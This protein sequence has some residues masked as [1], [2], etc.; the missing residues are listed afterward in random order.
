MSTIREALSRAGIDVKPLDDLNFDLD[1]LPSDDFVSQV[2]ENRVY[3]DA[4]YYNTVYAVAVRCLAE[5]RNNYERLSRKLSDSL[6]GALRTLGKPCTLEALR[7]V[8]SLPE[9][10]THLL[11]AFDSK[12]GWLPKLR[13]RLLP[14]TDPGGTPSSRIKSFPAKLTAA[15]FQDLEDLAYLDSNDF[16]KLVGSLKVSKGTAITVYQQAKTI[17]G[18]SNKVL[19][20][21]LDHATVIKSLITTV[22]KAVTNATLVS[23]N[24][25]NLINFIRRDCCSPSGDS[26]AFDKLDGS[27]DFITIGLFG[28]LTLITNFLVRIGAFPE[29]NKLPANNGQAEIHA[30]TTRFAECSAMRG[31]SVMIL[32]FV[33]GSTSFSNVQESDPAC[34]FLRFL[35]TLCDRIFMCLSEVMLTEL[36][37]EIGEAEARRLFECEVEKTSIKEDRCEFRKGFAQDLSLPPSDSPWTMIQGDNRVGFVCWEEINE[38]TV[39]TPLTGQIPISYFTGQFK[40]LLDGRE[41]CT[42]ILPY[43]N[44]LALL[45]LLNPT[46]AQALEE[47]NKRRIRNLQSVAKDQI[48]R[49]LMKYFQHEWELLLLKAPRSLSDCSAD[50]TSRRDA[51]GICLSK[52]TSVVFPSRSLSDCSAELDQTRLRDFVA[53]CLSKITSVVFLFEEFFPDKTQ[54]QLRDFLSLTEHE[55]KQRISQFA[56]DPP[57][58]HVPLSTFSSLAFEPHFVSEITSALKKKFTSQYKSLLKEIQDDVCNN[59]EKFCPTFLID[60]DT[61]IRTETASSQLRK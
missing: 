31:K 26:I 24:V 38:S 41:L 54:R 12:V 23:Q 35:Y 2:A 11:Q 17:V 33:P 57:R 55:M 22:G 50:Q 30:F 58:P 8:L 49:I 20:Y 10:P 52:A 56:S 19:H 7:E 48:Q 15:G 59:P 5:E 42:D 47:V 25:V 53:T 34:L 1:V 13:R 9:I 60:L 61:A 6:C 44:K 28:D 43:L 32:V 51:V 37:H 21:T 45:R 4:N 46:A 14:I 3:M 29:H 36:Q 40:D 27:C 39:Y 18:E 16:E